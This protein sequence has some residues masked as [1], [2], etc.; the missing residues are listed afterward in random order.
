MLEIRVKNESLDMPPGFTVGVEDTNPI[1]NERGSQSIPVTVP[2]TKRNDRLLGFPSRIDTDVAPNHPGQVA[3]V[4]DGAYRRRGVVNVTSAGRGAGITFNVGFDNSM[5][6]NRWNKKKLPELSGLPTVT[7]TD[8][9]RDDGVRGIT[10]YLYHIYNNPV[11]DVDPLAIF[12]IAINN[13]SLQDDDKTTVYWELLNVPTYAGDLQQP[14]SIKRLINGEVT[15]LKVPEGYGLSPFLRVWRLLELVFVDLGVVIDDN[16]FR[17]DKE[18][19]RLVVLNNTADTICAGSIRYSDLMPDCTV[20]EFMNALWV[21]FGLVYNINF[22]TGRVSLRLIRDIVKCPASR[23]I[24]DMT[25][26]PD[27][28]KYSTPQ[29]I[30]LSAKTSLEGAAPS[31]ERFE[32]FIKGLDVRN[33]HLGHDV[34]NWALTAG[35]KWDGDVRDVYWEF[36]DE[37]DYDDRD[38]GDDRDDDYDSRGPAGEPETFLAREFITGMWYKLD[39]LN[40]AVIESSSSFF[41]WDPSTPDMDPLDLVSDDECVPVISVSNVGLGT[42]NWFNGECPAYLVGPRHYHS[43]I[44]NSSA[45]EE[46]GA[47]TPLAFAL[48][49]TFDGRTIGRI[50]AEGSNGTPLTLDDGTHPTLSLLFQFKDG[51]FA[52]FWADYDEILRHGNRSVDVPL[53]V[54]KSDFSSLD[55]FTPLVFRGVRCLINTISYS[56][57]TGEHIAADVSLRTIS[58]H[59]DYDIRTEQNIPDFAAASRTLAW[60]L[61]SE[62]YGN[63]LFENQANRSRAADAFIQ[64]TGY[65]GHG[66]V[67]DYYEVASDSA[68]GVSMSRKLLTWQ[69]DKTIPEPNGP[70]LTI[71][72]TYQADLVYDIYEV[73]E[74]TT[75][76]GEVIRRR[77][78][79]PIGRITI[80][81]EYSVT[82]V[83]RWVKY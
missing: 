53:L 33:V 22:D 54:K 4:T 20:A 35:G 74:I 12:P 48:A 76:Q 57:P 44:L 2:A 26:A 55:M 9:G 75:P 13:E 64:Q 11:P 40:N 68:V 30:K 27:L 47:S 10:S 58:T 59:G 34:K 43:Y 67:D 32:D 38:E 52:K 72:R 16:I 66:S 5:A 49:Y 23:E 21:R 14:T 31:V 3:V 51:L 46:T 69:N 81:A 28:V 83:S 80:A 61:K 77:C 73:R 82:L 25:S 6:Y 42:G 1:F 24:I 15:D 36:Y 18:L 41:N 63:D 50:N 19:C 71:L 56:L 78:D 7:G 70:G 39:T 29:Y 45:S 79:E 60:V 65:R 17:S 62:A 37:Y 8:V